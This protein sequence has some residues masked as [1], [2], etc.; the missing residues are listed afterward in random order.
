MFQFEPAVLECRQKLQTAG[1][2][3][4]E[5]LDELESH[6]REEFES[7]LESGAT[8]ESAWAAAIASIGDSKILQRE[9]SKVN[10]T[11]R[12]P[13]KALQA[14]YFASIILIVVLNIWTLFAYEPSLT[15]KSSGAVVVCLIGLYLFWLPKW[16]RS[17]RWPW[18]ESFGRLLKILVNLI[19]LWGAWAILQATH[20]VEVEPAL[21]PTMVLLCLTA[22]I[23]LSGI[24]Y[25]LNEQEPPGSGDGY[26]PW[27][28]SSGEPI[29]PVRPVPP[30]MTLALEH[31]APAE[32]LIQQS[33]YIARYEA[34]QLG[35][36]Y[37]G[38]EHLL[39]GILKAA[40]GPFANLLQKMNLDEQVVR[41]EVERI[42]SPEPGG[43]KPIEIPLT[44]RA[45]RA[46]RL[47]SRECRAR[48]DG[49]F[50][51]EH[52]LLGLLREGS[53]VAAQVLRKLGVGVENLRNA[54]ANGAEPTADKRR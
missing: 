51:L 34:E 17:A 33:L 45:Q 18:R 8:A 1:I 29:P 6:L 26:P 54:I 35:H 3:R 22:A 27:P 53:G 14:F 11:S 37:I 13:R 44:P 31:L 48:A 21:V 40:T 43:T 41:G 49:T 2:T 46:I 9:F 30:D 16:L 20:V 24:A 42:V 5:I 12:R 36:S 19:W 32:R 39:L 7:R 47:A 52:V 23:G 25:V 50:G 15:A 4:P 10:R 28:L 38:T